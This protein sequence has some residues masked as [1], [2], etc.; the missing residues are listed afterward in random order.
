MS[1]QE[2]VLRHQ[3][4]VPEV[5]I[6]SL[7][8][9]DTASALDEIKSKVHYI[10]NPFAD[11]LLVGPNGLR[12]RLGKG[13][14]YY[15]VGKPGETLEDYLAR[16]GDRLQRCVAY[17]V[18]NIVYKESRFNQG[19]FTE[20]EARSGNDLGAETPMQDR[21]Q[22]AGVCAADFISRYGEDYGAR[23][24]VPFIGMENEEEETV[25]EILRLVQPFAYKLT[26][27]AEE[28][29][30]ELRD[31]ETLLF[32]LADR[33]PADERIRGAKLDKHL[34][35]LAHH[36]RRIMLG[37]T[38]QACVTARTMYAELEENLSNTRLGHKGYKK[39]PSVLDAHACNM[40]GVP[41]PA[42][43][44]TRPQGDPDLREGVKMLVNRAVREDEEKE[45]SLTEARDLLQEIREERA[46]LKKE[47]E[48]M[49]KQKASKPKEN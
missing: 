20:A 29:E 35:P 16:A 25:K 37:G 27:L 45:L 47:R 11:I 30:G 14:S 19:N 39:R 1:T 23:V 22:Y 49:Q 43:V 5:G 32:D 9:P 31:Q 17:P 48:Q 10:W 3:Q 18:W 8:Q 28:E 42:A 7:A 2:G 36:L 26:N 34:D 38:R 33:G 12:F 15:G 44:A 46:A 21:P 24:L 13:T 41:V 6:A 4:S 40:L